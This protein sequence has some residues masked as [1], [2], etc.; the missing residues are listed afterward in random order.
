MALTTEIIEDA[1]DP[2]ARFRRLAGRS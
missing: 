2:G 1:T